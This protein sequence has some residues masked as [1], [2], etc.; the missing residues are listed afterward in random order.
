MIAPTI[1]GIFLHGMIAL[2]HDRP[3]TGYMSAYLLKDS[4]H[5]HEAFLNFETNDLSR[6]NESSVKFANTRCFGVG[7]I[8]FC[9][10]GDTVSIRFDPISSPGSGEVPKHGPVRP[11]RQSE[12]SSL[13]WL[14]KMSDVDGNAGKAKILEQVRDHVLADF[15]FGWQQAMTCELDQVQEKDCNSDSCNYKIYPNRFQSN[16]SSSIGHVQ[17]LAEGAF[18]ESIFA[19]DQVT[20]YIKDIATGKE[21][22]LYFG[23]KGGKCP[24][25]E[26][27]NDA[28]YYGAES[29]MFDDVGAHFVSYYD[30]VVDSSVK[31][32]VPVRLTEDAVPLTVG[33]SRLYSCPRNPL[34]THRQ[35]ILEGRNRLASEK[36]KQL[37]QRYDDISALRIQSR[38]ICPMAM[39]EN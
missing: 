26:I 37:V 2:V 21:I 14:A 13:A 12:A 30:L 9:Y 27:D 24:D 8:C 39:F 10:I 33:A 4:A 34:Q 35:E 5:Q 18:F 32:K 28:A 25:L 16:L 15:S 1:L 38:I 7:A 31:K 36:E 20:V 23:C 17:A 29:D 6:C 3:G 22:K 19:N 11:L